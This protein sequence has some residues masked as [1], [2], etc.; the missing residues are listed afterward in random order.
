MPLSI[1]VVDDFVEAQEI[2]DEWQILAVACLV[3]MCVCAGHDVAEFVD[4]A[5][6][7]DPRRWIKRKGPADGPVTLLLRRHGA[8]KD[9][10]VHGCDD[11]RMICK[12]GFLHYPV[13]LGLAGKVGN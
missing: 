5:H 9:L 3:R 2:S 10:V 4:V 11:E 8:D 1:Q 12:P 13:D 6:V 7:N